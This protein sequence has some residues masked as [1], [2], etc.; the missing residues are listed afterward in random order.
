MIGVRRAKRVKEYSR[1][2]EEHLQTPGGKAEHGRFEEAREVQSY[3]SI[4]HKVG[5]GMKRE[6]KREVDGEGERLD[7]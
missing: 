5:G 7:F 3:L 1:Q 6:R 2:K 4:K